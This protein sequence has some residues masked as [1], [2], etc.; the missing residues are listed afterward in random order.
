M[1]LYTRHQLIVLLIL[2]GA[3]GLGLAVG[4]WRHAHPD[5]VDRLEMLDR[6]PAPEGSLA[7]PSADTP[8]APRRRE[9]DA[10]RRRTGERPGWMPSECCAERRSP[11]RAPDRKPVDVPIDLNRADAAELTR[12]PG[13][14]RTLAARIVAARETT[15]PFATVDDLQRVQGL[16]L[17]RID[18]FRAL[19]TASP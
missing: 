14:G 8:P 16:H 12:L 19:V 9:R 1:T 3:A 6:S 10:T 5:L 18:R 4:H 2:L 7:P 13:V 11:L 17:R 15:G